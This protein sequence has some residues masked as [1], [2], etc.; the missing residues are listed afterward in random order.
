MLS[1]ICIW[2]FVACFFGTIIEGLVLT[3]N[4]NSVIIIA[5]T[6]AIMILSIIIFEGL[7]QGKGNC[8]SNYR[9]KLDRFTGGEK[10]SG[11]LK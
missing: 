7:R 11:I 1:K 10:W 2:V 9:G 4:M 6:G 8:D 3:Q 5:V